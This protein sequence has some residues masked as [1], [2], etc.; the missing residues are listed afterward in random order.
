MHPAASLPPVL[1]DPWAATQRVMVDFLQM[2]D[3]SADPLILADGEGV[4][5]WD[6][7][8]RR[9]LD[10][11]SGVYTVS[12]GHRNRPAIEAVKAQLERIAFASP[13]MTTNLP[14]LEL[15]S[16]LA[17]V[18]PGTLNTVKFFSGGSEACEAAI[19]LARQYH[20]QTGNPHKF[21]IIGR[22]G[23]YHGATLGALAASGSADA[24]DLR[25]EEHTSEL[26][27]HSDLVCRLLLEK[28]KKNKKQCEN[29]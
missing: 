10:S 27:S 29:I 8:G 21:K 28:K 13:V 4:W 26:Q 18:S 9:Y 16:L 5:V 11:V 22:Y 2:K 25:S 20:Q 19:K 14:A 6:V 12:V 24:D 3:F 1:S 17:E 7:D 23:D 15:A